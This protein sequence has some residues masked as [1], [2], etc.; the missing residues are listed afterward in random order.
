MPTLGYSARDHEASLRNVSIKDMQ[1]GTECS[2]VAKLVFFVCET[3]NST[4][5][6]VGCGA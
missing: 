3:L 6:M 1:W 2:S 4:P 5:N